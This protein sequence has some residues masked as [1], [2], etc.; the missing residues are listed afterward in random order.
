MGWLLAWLLS[1]RSM[2]VVGDCH[3]E[4]GRDLCL[5]ATGTWYI[6]YG[7]NV[8]YEG[9]TVYVD[10][11]PI[12]AQQYS[13]P[14]LQSAASVEQPAPPLPPPDPKQ[15][16]DWMPLG[17]FALAQEERGD[18]VMF[19]QL[20]INPDGVINGAFQSTLTGD[21]RPGRGEGG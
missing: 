4:L 3:M 11:K 16:G 5:D 2:V 13:G 14:I 1:A 21:S 15:P 8:I 17:V 6:D 9:D 19:F 10:N 12:P 7:M 20:S 18:P